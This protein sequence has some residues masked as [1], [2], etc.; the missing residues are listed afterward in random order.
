MTARVFRGFF[1]TAIGVLVVSVA[2]I[3]ALCFKS[4]NARAVDEIERCAEYISAGYEAAGTSYFS[5]VSNSDMKILLV[6]SDGETLYSSYAYSFSR[7]AVLEKSEIKNALSGAPS[8][9]RYKDEETGRAMLHYALLLP[10]GNI[11]SVAA[12]SPGAHSML[13]EMMTPIISLIT[14]VIVLTFIAAVKLSMSVVEP[15]NELDLEHPENNE[16]S[17]ELKP[18]I[19]KLTSQKY[20]ISHQMAELRSRENEFNNLTE[21]MNVGMV[22]INSKTDII[23][24]NKSARLIFGI[25]DSAV[26]NVLALK[27]TEGFRDAIKEALLGRRAYDYLRTDEKYYTI[28]VTPVERDGLVDGAVIV[29]IDETEKE[30]RETLRREFT[31]NVSHELKTPLTSISGF[32]ELISSGLTTTDDSV[33]FADNIYKEAQRLITLVGDIIRLNQLDGKEIPYDGIINLYEVADEVVERLTN[34]AERKN[35]KI[36][37]EGDRA[38]VLGTYLILEEIIYNLID[39]AIKYNKDGG[40]VTVSVNEKNSIPEISVS[41]TG[42]GIPNDKQD[43]VFERFY[44]VDKSHSKKIGGT[45]LGLSI[46]KHAALYHKANINLESEEGVGTTITITFPPCK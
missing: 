10:E 32:A 17:V 44:R 16:S 2:M 37:L 33:H 9:E 23:S 8:A 22:V 20:R 26:K 30:H 25:G 45:G 15:I 5:Y 46:V 40:L 39:N 34:V 21:N 29:V 11:L 28:S 27:D 6:K 18:I 1:I 38:D 12:P 4:Y 3:F 14:L 24:C 41:D 13:F 19:D 35:V 36:K 31:S 42:I 7:D 43:R